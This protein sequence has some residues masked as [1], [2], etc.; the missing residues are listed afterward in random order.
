MDLRCLTARQEFLVIG[1]EEAG[2]VIQLLGTGVPQ[3]ALP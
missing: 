1:G 3:R 2:R